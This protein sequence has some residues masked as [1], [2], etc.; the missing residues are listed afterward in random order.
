MDVYLTEIAKMI[1]LSA[2]GNMT[3]TAT[4]TVKFCCEM[5]RIALYLI[6]IDNESMSIPLEVFY[7]NNNPALQQTATKHDNTANIRIQGDAGTDQLAIGIYRND[8]NELLAWTKY[9]LP[10]P[11]WDN[12]NRH[13]YYEYL[14]FLLSQ[15]MMFILFP[16][17][18]NNIITY[19]WWNDNMAA[20]NWA[21]HHVCR[22]KSSQYACMF[23]NWIQI[24]SNILMIKPV[25]ISGIEMGDIDKASRN[26][27]AASLPLDKYI[28]IQDDIIINKIFNI[29]SP[30]ITIMHE[31]EQ[32]KV[33]LEI[34]E[35][36]SQLKHHKLENVDF[37]L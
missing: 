1:Y 21:L 31:N 16:N 7:L 9:K 37:L 20:L 25:F 23:V 29:T 28:H 11:E 14:V 4:A 33:L 26:N 13:T 15:I 24:N 10:Y 5:W 35:I 8:T 17:D 2:T 18:S 34:H 12:V 30:Y 27:F 36:M 6:F 22:T 19:Q 3:A 32:H